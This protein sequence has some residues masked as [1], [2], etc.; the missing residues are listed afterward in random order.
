MDYEYQVPTSSQRDQEDDIIVV[1]TDDEDEDES[2]NEDGPFDEEN[3]GF[4]MENYEQEQ[5]VVG[6]Y[7]D[8]DD[9]NIQSANNEVEIEDVSEV[10]NQSGSVIPVASDAASTSGIGQSSSSTANNSPVSDPSTLSDN[11]QQIQSITSGTGN[12]AGASTSSPSSASTSQ[13]RQNPNIT[14][15]Q[16]QSSH[17]M[18]MHQNYDETPDDRIV[19]STPTLYANRRSDG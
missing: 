2:M 16:H 5:E 10:P 4:Q 12:E 9:D 13:W 8:I 14:S 6:G 11:P 7:A 17:L 3:E 1:D 18:L 15:R 19:P